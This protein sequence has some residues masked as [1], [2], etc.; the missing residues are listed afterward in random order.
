MAQEELDGNRRPIAFI[1][2]K[3]TGVKDYQ[4]S[5]FDAQLRLRNKGY[6]VLNPAWLPQ[7][8]AYKKYAPI[9]DAMLMQSDLL[10]L[11]SGWEGSIGVAHELEL[12]K[13]HNIPIVPLEDVE[14][15]E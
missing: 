5:F 3:I 10:V 6:I 2:G 8:M 14:R 12:A 1:A 9:D 4:K 15:Y 13:K 7:G 11:L